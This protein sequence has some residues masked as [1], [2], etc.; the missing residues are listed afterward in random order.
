MNRQ[1]RRNRF[2]NSREI[3]DREYGQLNS[4]SIFMKR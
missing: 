3:R 4:E 2:L 1:D